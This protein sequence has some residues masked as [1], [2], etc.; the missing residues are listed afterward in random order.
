METGG[1][2]E[3]FK[4]RVRRRGQTSKG[5]KME[6]LNFTCCT[7]GPCIENESEDAAASYVLPKTVIGRVADNTN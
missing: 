3:E 2:G 7:H 6:A 5:L 4:A 1:G